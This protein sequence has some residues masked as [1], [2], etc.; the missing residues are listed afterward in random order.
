MPNREFGSGGLTRL[1]SG[2]ILADNG[3]GTFLV[4]M[5]GDGIGV[6][7][8]RAPTVRIGEVG[9]VLDLD[10]AQ[11]L[12]GPRTGDDQPYDALQGLGSFEQ[13]QVD[14]G[15]D[16]G[17]GPVGW[18]SFWGTDTPRLVGPVD[19]WQADGDLSAGVSVT[20]SSARGQALILLDAIIAPAQNM[21][22]KVS[23]TYK[24]LAAQTGNRVNVLV[25]W[26]TTD[27]QAQPFGGGKVSTLI[28]HTL[29]SATGEVAFNV[30]AP[31]PAGAYVYAR[32]YLEI[33]AKTSATYVAGTVAFDG[34]RAEWLDSGSTDT[35][36]LDW[37]PQLIATTTNPNLGT[38]G[39]GMTATG[40]YTRIGSTV[41]AH[42]QLEAGTSGTAVG[43]GSY[44]VTLPV[45]QPA[46]KIITATIQMRAAAGAFRVGHGLASPGSATLDRLYV[47]LTTYLADAVIHSGPVAVN[48]SG[49][50][51]LRGFVTYEAALPEPV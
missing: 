29:T 2:E 6:S 37:T 10:G 15:N 24:P 33:A 34:V 21:N 42:F 38:A 39:S 40:R 20:S 17:L 19:T 27:A 35:P 23:G 26:G 9:T 31:M 28:A 44:G 25:Y 51:R 13:W 16:S 43:S 49:F 7:V 45:A 47:P 32:V 3:D 18:I 46:G 4:D 1:L 5:D 22:L 11:V 48:N 8:A 41:H 50:W 30:T 36:W 14:T 12:I